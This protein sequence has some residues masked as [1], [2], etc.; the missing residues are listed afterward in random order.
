MN[1][2]RARELLPIIE[3]FA[4]GEEIQVNSDV[5]GWTSYTELSFNERA[6]D[7][8]IKPKPREFWISNFPEGD[9]RSNHRTVYDGKGPPHRSTQW[10]KVREIEDL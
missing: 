4:N 10:I 2:E 8:R 6:E 1:R 5:L 7:Y 9:S 3:A